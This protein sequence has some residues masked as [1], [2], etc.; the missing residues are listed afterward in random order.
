MFSR[1]GRS[2]Y[3]TGIDLWLDSLTRR[4]RSYI[5]HGH[6][7]HARPHDLVVATPQTAAI[8]RARFPRK[9]ILSGSTM[10][11]EHPYESP[12]ESEH[13]RLTLISAGHVLGSSQLLIEG[14][15]G[16]FVYTGDFKLGTSR[17]CEE[18]RVPRC[19]TLL[20]ECTFGEPHFV[21]PPRQE[22]E[23]EMI[24]FANETHDA[25]ALPTFLAYSLGKAQEAM[26]ILGSAGIPLVVHDA[27]ATIAD[28]YVQ[29]GVA[30]PAYRRF[31]EFE[32][33]S[34]GAALVWPPAS[35]SLPRMIAQK[36]VVA[37]M[38]TGWTADKR[39]YASYRSNRGFSL[40]DHAD[41]PALLRYIELAQPTHVVL[42]HGNQGFARH[43]RSV[44]INAQVLGEHEQLSLLDPV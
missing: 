41:Y 6:A 39:S 35:K 15:G 10:F 13:H 26:A 21:F 1:V 29:C 17:T 11:E 23:A 7:D 28:V 27:I 40:S 9:A 37:A 19:D 4:A 12:W 36:N 30:L 24:S 33:F 5:S 20:M 22:V 8:C 16:R 14:E 34:D 3:A 38:L 43:L 42:F 31:T 32:T 18:A 25:G 2:I 44:G